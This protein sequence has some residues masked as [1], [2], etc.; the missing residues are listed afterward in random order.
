MRLINEKHLLP[1]AML[2]KY[3]TVPFCDSVQGNP[4][5]LLQRDRFDYCKDVIAAH[6]GSWAEPSGEGRASPERRQRRQLPGAAER[7]WPALLQ[8]SPAASAAA[9]GMQGLE[10]GDG[11]VG[12]SWLLLRLCDFRGTELSPQPGSS[13]QKARSSRS[14]PRKRE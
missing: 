14:I 10:V 3:I 8:Q 4:F 5:V 11:C 7:W 2:F 6:Q 12:E 9:G 13:V 1:P